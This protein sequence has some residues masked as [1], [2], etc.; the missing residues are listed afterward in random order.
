MVRHPF[1]GQ[2]TF[3]SILL[4]AAA[5]PL[6]G[7]TDSI[8]LSSGT[9]GS[10]GTISLNLTLTA[11]A[12]SEPAALQWT[13]TYSQSDVTAISVSAGAAATGASKTLAWL[14]GSGGYTCIVS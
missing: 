7:Q 12:G 4:L 2:N 5:S 13:L 9:A 14:A 10:D 3:I 6:I 1:R 8:G 11:P